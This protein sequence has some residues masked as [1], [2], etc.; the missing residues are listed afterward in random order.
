MQ[1]IVIRLSRQVKRQFR[2][3]IGKIKD[4]QLK[5]RYLII[6]H[7]AEGYS[8]RQIAKMLLCSSSTVDRLRDRQDTFY[9]H[10]RSVTRTCQSLS[11]EIQVTKR[12]DATYSSP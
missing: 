3:A 12:V 7:T 6:L 8:R 5:T 4:G 11:A 9:P 2:R 10:R 1:R